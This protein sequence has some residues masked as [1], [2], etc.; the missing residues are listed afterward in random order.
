MTAPNAELQPHAP[1]PPKTDFDDTS[2]TVVKKTESERPATEEEATETLKNIKAEIDSEVTQISKSTLEATAALPKT[3]LTAPEKNKLKEIWHKM[4]E[5]TSGFFQ[6]IKNIFKDKDKEEPEIIEAEDETSI[7]S[8]EKI[9]F[10]TDREPGANQVLID[11]EGRQI[12]FYDSENPNAVEVIDPSNTHSGKGIIKTRDGVTNV[13]LEGQP[14]FFRVNAG[15]TLATNQPTMSF[16]EAVEAGKRPVVDSGAKPPAVEVAMAA[17]EHPDVDQ[18]RTL[19][20]DARIQSYDALSQ[21]F[22]QQLDQLKKNG[23]VDAKEHAA[24]KEQ[25]LRGKVEFRFSPVKEYG[26]LQNTW[27]KLEALRKS[28]FI[29]AEARKPAPTLEVQPAP[30]A[31]AVAPETAETV[32]ETPIDVTAVEVEDNTEEAYENAVTEAAEETQPSV[33]D[34]LVQLQPKQSA[35]NEKMD[36]G[37][38][39]LRSDAIL[40]RAFNEKRELLSPEQLAELPGQDFSHV[41]FGY[42]SPTRELVITDVGGNYLTHLDEENTRRLLNEEILEPESLRPFTK[43]YAVEKDPK[44]YA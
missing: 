13:Q 15:E 25:F 28:K 31:A 21:K 9:Y 34:N 32:A 4:S 11:D 5:A 18:Q 8:A 27:N 16:E 39:F 42:H 36:N 19:F 20:E 12:H 26:D 38:V 3:D 1:Q 29:S 30:Q 24:L 6:K 33:P 40:E 14:F 22:M 23:V 10:M 41:Q 2:A 17:D 35:L 44:I 37:P 43:A 7:K